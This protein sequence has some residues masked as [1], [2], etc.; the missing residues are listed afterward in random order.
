MSLISRLAPFSLFHYLRFKMHA[1]CFVF[2]FLLLVTLCCRKGKGDQKCIIRGPGLP[3]C[4][5]VKRK[6]LFF[7]AFMKAGRSK[8][9]HSWTWVAPF[10]TFL[11]ATIVQPNIIINLLNTSYEGHTRKL[12]VGLYFNKINE[13]CLT[14]KY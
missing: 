7:K 9:C 10:V 11:N 13:F 6:S 5:S 4:S 3:P 12:I 14:Q 2:I 1:T 8:A